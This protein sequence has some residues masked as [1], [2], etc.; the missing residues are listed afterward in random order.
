MIFLA[1]PT[2]RYEGF[3]AESTCRSTAVYL[4]ASLPGVPTT[5]S[6]SREDSM[7]VDM[8]N[9]GGGTMMSSLSTDTPPTLDTEFRV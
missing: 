8:L 3:S 9:R 2:R 7:H 5:S 6:D 4:H 1:H